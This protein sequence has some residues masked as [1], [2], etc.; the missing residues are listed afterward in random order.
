MNEPEM[1]SEFN[2]RGGV[3]GKY[4][5]Q[6]WSSQTVNTTSNA[7]LYRVE[8]DDSVI[9]AR[10]WLPPGAAASWKRGIWA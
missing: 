6:Y 7:T 2:L 4:Y 10:D 1:P 5:G 3:R 9:E 8:C